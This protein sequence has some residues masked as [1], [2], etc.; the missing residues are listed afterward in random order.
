[1]L[2]LKWHPGHFARLN[3]PR[4]PVCRVSWQEAGAFCAG[5]RRRPARSSR[6][7]TKRSGSGPAGRARTRPGASAPRA[8]PTS[9]AFANLADDSLLDLGRLAAMEKV[10]PF[11]AVEPVNDKQAGFR[12]GRIVPA[13]SLGPLR[14]ARQRGR[15]D[16]QRLSAVSVPPRRSAPRRGRRPQ[17]GPRRLLVPACRLGAFG[18]PHELLAWQR[19]FN[20]G[21]RVVCGL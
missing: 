12:P 11:F 15:V 8:A 19:V 3:Q 5:C 2:W 16:R 4:Q 7:P 17:G 6:C 9:A 10:R 18:V 1:M 13:Q 20:V 14:H 21:F